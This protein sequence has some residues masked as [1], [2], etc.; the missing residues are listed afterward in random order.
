[1]S[2]AAKRKIDLHSE[3][4]V[5]NEGFDRNEE[6]SRDRLRNAPARK[7]GDYAV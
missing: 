6:P 1:M 2:R 5:G 3:E 4:L 7:Y